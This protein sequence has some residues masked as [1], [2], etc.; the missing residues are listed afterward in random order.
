MP[1][2][3][4]ADVA[5]G[6][7][8]SFK[9]YALQCA[10]AFGAC[11]TLRDEP[12]SSEIPE[13]EADD[14]YL[15]SL[16]EEK[17]RLAEF[18]AMNQEQRQELYQKQCDNNKKIAEEEIE[19]IAKVRERYEAMLA[20]AKAFK[21]P[22]AKHHSFAIFLVEQLEESIRHDCNSDYYSKLQ[23][24]PKY[25]EWEKE[26]ISDLEWSI[27]YYEEAYKKNLK[28]VEDRNKW[29]KQLKEALQQ[30]E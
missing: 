18:M 29:V 2:G 22:S 23:E 4:T 21:P 1:T 9:E 19:R 8:T 11:I 14:Y 12:L 16:Q 20:K 3:Y 6:K 28:N 10:R 30:G 17:Q 7:I 25:E 5:D 24:Y 26:Y 27:N 15:K 13:F